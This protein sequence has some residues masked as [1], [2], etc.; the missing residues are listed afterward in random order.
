METQKEN[1]S[2][3]IKVRWLRIHRGYVCSVGQIGFV[4]PADADIL[5]SAFEEEMPSPYVKILPDD[6]EEPKAPA[7]K[8]IPMEDHIKVRFLK[9]HENFAYAQ[10]A[11]G[12]VTPEHAILLLEG[13]YIELL[14]ENYTEPVIEKKT[15]PI[16]KLVE[17]KWLKTHP[18]Y[19]SLEGKTCLIEP[20]QLG[21][22]VKEGYVV[23][24]H[25]KVQIEKKKMIDKLKGLIK[26]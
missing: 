15:V 6:Y 8:I 16:S 13:D 19:V 5:T 21:S 26:K 10:N 22:L 14:P 20:D 23:E 3:L 11:V 7:P 9:H 24:T 1:Q 25:A 18:G 12:F 2:K 4:T 17:V